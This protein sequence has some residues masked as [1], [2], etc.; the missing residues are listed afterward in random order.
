MS[1]IVKQIEYKGFTINIYP[2]FAPSNPWE[3]WDCQPPLLVLNDGRFTEYGLNARAP[4]LTRDQIKAPLPALKKA[5]GF[6]R[7]LPFC[8]DYAASQRHVPSAS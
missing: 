8:R 4:Q 3:E 7:L 1:E 5:F 2:D 6:D